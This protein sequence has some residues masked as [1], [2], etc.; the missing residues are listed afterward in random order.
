MIEWAQVAELRD[1]VGPDDFG[2][3]VEVF[4]E[5]VEETLK[6]MQAAPDPDGLAGDMHFL[7]GSALHLGFTDLAHLCAQGETL[8]ADDRADEIDLTALSAVFAKSKAAFLADL[9]TAFAA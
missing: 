7:K 5:E 3:V 8:A 2:E 9:P 6:R 1:A 4:V